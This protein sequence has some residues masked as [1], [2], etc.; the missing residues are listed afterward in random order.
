MKA[1][2][3]AHGDLLECTLE[4]PKRRQGGKFV[5]VIGIDPPH[6][7]DQFYY[8]TLDVGSGSIRKH[9]WKDLEDYYKKIA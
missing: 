4:Y 2:K 7:D 3:W 1:A 5:V 9:F 6:I 8:V